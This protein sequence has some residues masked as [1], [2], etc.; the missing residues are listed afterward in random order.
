MIRAL[1]TAATGMDAQQTK[2]DV[3]ANNIA[4]VSTTGYK[5]SRAEFQ[6]LMYQTLRAPVGTATSGG[7]SGTPTGIQVGLGVRAG[8]T[9]R[10]HTQGDPKITNSPLDLTI[11]GTGFFKIEMPNGQI[12]YTRDGTFKPNSDG[13]IVTSDGYHLHGN[14]AL[15]PDANNIHIGPDGVVTVT[16]PGAEAAPTEVGKIEL[17]TFVNPAGLSPQGRN[18]FRE[19]GAS[20][21]PVHAVPGENGAGSIAQGQLEMS[22]VSVVEEMVDLISGQRAY[23]VNSRVIKAA[24]EMLQTT[25]NLR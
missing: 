24:D 16:L 7:V 19:S 6:D 13:K 12:A 4:N 3:T 11:E 2:L 20:G 10:I 21:P 23:E 15:P 9:Q 17:A 8:A 25:S 1:S 14:I 18:L 5:K 22:N